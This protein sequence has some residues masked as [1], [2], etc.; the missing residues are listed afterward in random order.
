MFIRY[1]LMQHPAPFTFIRPK[2]A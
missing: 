2:W 1:L